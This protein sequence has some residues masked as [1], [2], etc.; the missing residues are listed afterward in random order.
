MAR[1]EKIQAD[2][3]AQGLTRRQLLELNACARCGE[4]QAWC[5]VYAQ[6]S[7]EAVTARGKLDAL[8]RLVSGDLPKERQKEFVQALYECSACGQCHVVCPVRID[9]HELWE[10]ARLSLV[11]AGIPQPEGQ[12]KQLAAIRQ[13]NNPFG[14][15]QSERP[16]WAETPGKQGCSKHPSP[17]GGTSAL[18]SSISPAAW[19]ALNPRSSPLLSSRQD[20]CRKPASVSRSWARTSRAA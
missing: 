11:D 15:P 18:R 9:T 10:Q 7:R 16:G 19:Q 14:K 20:F 2:R 6:D 5:P 12:I 8:R 13:F 17:C 4:C 1:D 3:I